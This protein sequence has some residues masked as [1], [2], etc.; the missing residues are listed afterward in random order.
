MNKNQKNPTTTV[1]ATEEV[2]TPVTAVE[3]TPNAKSN[4]RKTS[5]SAKEA[6][7]ICENNQIGEYTTEEA[8]AI[9]KAANGTKKNGTSRKRDYTDAKWENNETLRDARGAVTAI[10]KKSNTNN[11]SVVNA[12]CIMCGAFANPR[13][14][15]ISEWGMFSYKGRQVYG[16]F[17]AVNKDEQYSTT[18][19]SKNYDNSIIVMDE[20]YDIEVA[21][22]STERWIRVSQAMKDSKGD[23][24][25]Q[26]NAKGDTVN[27]YLQYCEMLEA[28]DMVA[29]SFVGRQDIK[30]FDD[31]ELTTPS[32]SS[33]SIRIEIPACDL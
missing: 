3:S 18:W 1:N 33:K 8:I 29:L 31:A 30:Q 10:D 14:K 12:R 13:T 22:I 11:V 20:N 9:I 26:K 7:D 24:M 28:G 2:I 23:K 27:V 32:G 15:K 25:K 4:N 6:Q 19:T 17:S 16:I 5:W 21:S